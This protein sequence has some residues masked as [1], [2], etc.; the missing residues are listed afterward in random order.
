MA[1]FSE[2]PAKSEKDSLSARW[3]AETSCQTTTRQ[4]G[5]RR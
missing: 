1:A 5:E 3:F 2:S 4:P